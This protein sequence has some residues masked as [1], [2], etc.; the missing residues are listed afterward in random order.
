[1]APSP[2][3]IKKAV[4][5]PITWIAVA[6]TA[7]AAFEGFS[8]KKYYD[9]VGVA[10]ICYGATAADG[11]DLS[12]VYTKAECMDMLGKDLVKYD[13][14]IKRC[15]HLDVYNALPPQR[16]AALVSFDYNVGGGAFCKSSVARDLN[17]GRV[18][19]ACDDLLA[20][21]HAGGRVLP[22]LTNRREAERKMCLAEAASAP[23]APATAPK[24]EPPPITAPKP[25]TPPPSL[26]QRIWHWLV[27][28]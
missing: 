12:K 25:E 5:Q 19:Q 2:A 7:V 10:T 22:G 8:S 3:P 1:M 21:N 24:P 11:V 14:D 17:S 28:H 23:A 9:S 13:T 15:L 6:V 20:Y 26:W 18:Q 27:T 4:S 16:H